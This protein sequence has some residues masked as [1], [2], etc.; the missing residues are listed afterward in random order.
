M[1]QHEEHHVVSPLEEKILLGEPLSREE[2]EQVRRHPELSSLMADTRPLLHALRTGNAAEQAAPHI[3][4]ITWQRWHAALRQ[5]LGHQAPRRRSPIWAMALVAAALVLVV[6][7]GKLTTSRPGP[8]VTPTPVTA[9]L[10]A[11]AAETAQIASVL[12]EDLGLDNSAFEAA[13]QGETVGAS[14]SYID[15]DEALALLAV[16]GV[17][18]DTPGNG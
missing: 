13:A 2:Q 14:F 4:E 18:D 5:R 10:P 6:G 12:A 7:I 9:A 11:E 8:T 16:M 3:D 1:S 17:M 15:D